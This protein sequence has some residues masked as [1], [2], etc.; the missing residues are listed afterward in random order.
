MVGA[1][2]E[3]GIP[4]VVDV[5]TEACFD[6]H[7]PSRMVNRQS[8]RTTGVLNPFGYSGLNL[9]HEGM[10][11]LTRQRVS[12]RMYVY[13]H[14]VHMVGSGAGGSRRDVGSLRHTYS[15]YDTDV[16]CQEAFDPIRMR[17]ISLVEGGG[18][19]GER[20]TNIFDVDRGGFG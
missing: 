13:E 4:A 6:S 12:N 2:S 8:R 9:S 10:A 17:V 5:V 7:P 11:S 14:M 1:I 20:V 15:V 19:S 3:R 16:G 18:A